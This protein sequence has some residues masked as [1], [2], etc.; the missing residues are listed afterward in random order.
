MIPLEVVFRL[1]GELRA[2]NIGLIGT[3]TGRD[4]FAFG[5]IHGAFRTIQ[6]IEDRLTK[7]VEESNQGE[8]S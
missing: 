5:D 4:A 2:D 6:E 8:E 3:P 7:L 1:L